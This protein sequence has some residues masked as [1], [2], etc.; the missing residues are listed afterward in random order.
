ML[1]ALVSSAEAARVRTTQFPLAS[2][3]LYPGVIAADPEG[4]MWFSNRKDFYAKEIDRITQS[5]QITRFPAP[6][7][8]APTAMTAGPDDNMWSVGVSGIPGTNVI[9]RITLRGQ[10]TQFF[11]QGGFPGGIATGPDGNVWF[12]QGSGSV[13]GNTIDRITPSGQ[14]TEFSIPT[15]ESDPRAITAGPDGSLWFTEHQGNKI[16]RITPSGRIREFPLPNKNSGPTGITKG[17]EGSLWFTEQRPGSPAIGRITTSGRITQFPLPSSEDAPEQIA[18]GGDGRLWFADQEQGM[19]RRITPTGRIALVGFPYGG[20]GVGLS[21]ADIAAGPGGGI[22]YTAGESGCHGG[23]LTCQNYTPQNSGVV[24]HITPGPLTGE[25]VSTRAP[26]S[27]RRAELK[28]AC[29][30]GDTNSACR[31]RIWMSIRVR[32]RTTTRPHL[33][34]VKN[35]VLASTNYRLSVAKIMPISLPLTTRA[36]ALLARHL[37]LRV[38]AIVSVSGGQGARRKIVL[39]R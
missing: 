39:E 7:Q 20:S 32:R 13:G 6:P 23:G 38:R 37:Q 30:G 21:L 27:G 11:S 16:G 35:I 1:L 31:G 26:V 34:P 8:P 2:D 4:N 36:L 15:A 9:D 25:I 10:F 33:P 18:A 17:P 12:T 22:W 14:I 19:I 3:D 24:G 5:G 29:L 28:L